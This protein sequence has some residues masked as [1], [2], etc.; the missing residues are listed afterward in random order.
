MRTLR[1]YVS[2]RCLLGRCD[3]CACLCLAHPEELLKR[4]TMYGPVRRSRACRMLI[5]VSGTFFVH[6]SNDGNS[7]RPIRACHQWLQASPTSIPAYAGKPH[8]LIYVNS[9]QLVA[10]RACTQQAVNSITAAESCLRLPTC[11][12]LLRLDRLSEDPQITLAMIWP[13]SSWSIFDNM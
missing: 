5:T 7:F 3:S 9:K 13:H 8:P 10:Q 6:L 4:L 2:Y 12:F 1:P 11:S